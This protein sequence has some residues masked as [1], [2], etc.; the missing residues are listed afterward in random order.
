MFYIILAGILTIGIVVSI[1]TALFGPKSYTDARGNERNSKV[2]LGG[3]VAA[4]GGV[5]LLAVLT[6]FSSFTQVE[7]RTVAIQTSFGRYTSTLEAGRHFVAPWSDL[8]SFSTTIQ[9]TDLNDLDG[10]KNSVNVTFSSPK[11]AAN[12]DA[13]AVAG[14]GTGNINAIVNWA[15]STE[16]GNEG[17]KALWVK[18]RTF[19]A[20]SERLVLSRAQDTIAD[21]ANDFPAGEAAVNQTGIGKEV[22]TRLA[23]QLRPYGIVIDSVSIK[24]VDLDDATKASLQRIVDNINKTTAA[25]EEQKRAIIDNETAELRAKSGAL[26]EQSLTRTCLDI[27]N[28]WDVT[29]NG[30]LPAT[31]NCGLGGNSQTGVLVQSK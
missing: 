15:I 9:S 26:S 14:G 2:R 4:L 13:K 10:S 31:F 6:F 1:L 20:V 3:A 25:Q 21:V 7:A 23:E 17:T 16:N 8:E 19:E 18:W 30:P 29:K 28:A 27:V 24:R 12:K 5:F 22:Q 11:D